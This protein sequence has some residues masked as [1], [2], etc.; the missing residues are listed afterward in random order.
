MKP[1][2]REHEF[3]GMARL[4]A[5]D[6]SEIVEV[7]RLLDGANGLRGGDAWDPVV[8]VRLYRRSVLHP[9]D[10]LEGGD[11]I[12]MR[13]SDLHEF[14]GAL[15]AVVESAIDAGMLPGPLSDAEWERRHDA[16]GPARPRPTLRKTA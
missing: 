11:G 12:E 8:R 9:G 7:E 14:V 15:R 16:L 2:T 5:Q 4:V 3:T 13:A 10:R 6:E 1:M